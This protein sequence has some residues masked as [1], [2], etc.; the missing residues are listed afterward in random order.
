MKKRMRL[1]VLVLFV[2]V[3]ASTTYLARALTEPII[4]PGTVQQILIEKGASFQEVS[5]KLVV[6]GVTHSHTYNW[7]AAKLLRAEGRIK[8]GEYHLS[9]PLGMLDI[10]MLLIEG[11]SVFHRTTLF[12]G[13][14]IEEMLDAMRKN[15]TLQSSEDPLQFFGFNSPRDAEGHCLPNTYKHYRGDTDVQI[16]ALCIRAMQ[17]LLDELWANRSED[18][19]YKTPQEAVTLASIIEAETS[20]DDER[21]IIAGVLL[22]RLE[23]GM[24]LQVDPSVIYGLG[25]D[26]DNNLTR[27]HLRQSAEINPYNTYRIYGL[28][29]GPIGNPGRKSL[30]AAFNPDFSTGALYYVSK[31]DGRHHFSKTYKEHRAS[32]RKYQLGK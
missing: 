5:D 3:T 26:F 9:G 17:E 13:W 12:E 31:G 20:Q 6:L 24:R 27:K 4:E 32:V 8:A 23:Q 30:E 2:A 19:P 14:T 15:P 21:S 1:G 7:L 18:L 28:P 29:P 10:M 16:L 25:P 11:R 22:S